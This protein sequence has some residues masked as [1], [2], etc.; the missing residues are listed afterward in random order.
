MVSSLN[1]A[2]EKEARQEGG[3]EK[4]LLACVYVHFC[5]CM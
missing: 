1:P 2:P 4:T 3:L 5:L